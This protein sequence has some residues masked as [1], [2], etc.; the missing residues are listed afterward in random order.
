MERGY[1]VEK[2]HIVTFEWKIKNISL[3]LQSESSNRKF[4]SPLFS[5][6]ADVNNLWELHLDFNN[7]PQ[8]VAKDFVS[9]RL[10]SLI[11]DCNIQTEFT[12]YILNN[13][14]VRTN[15][16]T[17][18]HVFESNKTCYEISD[19]IVKTDQLLI[20]EVLLPHDALT[21]GVELVIFD[22]TPDVPIKKSMNLMTQDYKQ[23]LDNKTGSDIVLAVGDQKFEAHKSILMARSPV[24]LTMFT[25]NM[26]ESSE[27]EI[28]ISDIEPE[29]FKNI[30]YSIY[31]DEVT[32][33]DENAEDLLEA[34]DRFQLLSLKEMCEESLCKSVTVE[35]AITILTLAKRHNAKQLVDFVAGFIVKN[36]DKVVATPE[37]NIMEESHPSLVSILFRKSVSVKGYKF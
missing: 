37:Y 4:R 23:L 30:L 2:K 3:Y 12:F 9:I 33:L 6:K 29:I 14:K 31:T 10:Q 26:K 15:D 19:Y 7:N 35:R 11:N 16:R 21:V 17:L 13:E 5:A 34:A 8:S 20:Q 22:N 27:R 32:E 1:T 18:M 36:G 28:T 25:N 24:F